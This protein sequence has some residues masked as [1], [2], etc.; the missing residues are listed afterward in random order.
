MGLA[1]WSKGV[2]TMRAHVVVLWVVAIPTLLVTACSLNEERTAEPGI[3]GIPS[4]AVSPSPGRSVSFEPP[5]AGDLVDITFWPSYQQTE[6]G[7]GRY[8]YDLTGFAE[9]VYLHHSGLD[10]HR[11]KLEGWLRLEFPDHSAE[12]WYHETIPWGEGDPCPGVPRSGPWTECLI[13]S[14]DGELVLVGLTLDVDL[15]VD[16]Q[17]VEHI[18]QHYVGPDFGPLRPVRPSPCMCSSPPTEQEEVPD[19]EGDISPD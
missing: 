8:R 1:T 15:T 18:H 19:Q 2:W 10:S 9:K 12:T 4:E 14:H 7:W 16:G 5:E 6:L 11:V 17:F 3:T 13:R